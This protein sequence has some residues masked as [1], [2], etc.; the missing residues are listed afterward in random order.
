[1]ETNHVYSAVIFE[2]PK[3]GFFG[4]VL[5]VRGATSF[6]RTK[7]E[8]II[9]LKDAIYCILEANKTSSKMTIENDM[10]SKFS[11]FKKSEVALAC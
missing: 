8:L 11:S 2:T 1:M 7:E 10:E 4:L 6:A 3:S 9:R 5:E